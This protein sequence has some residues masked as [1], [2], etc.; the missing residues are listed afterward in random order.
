MLAEQF[1]PGPLTIILP[2]LPSLAWD[3]GDSHGTVAL[4]IPEHAVAL[5]LLRQTGPLAVTGAQHVGGHVP[6]TVI[7]AREHLD[8]AVAVYLDGGPVAGGVSS[9][10]DAT[11]SPPMLVREGVLSLDRLRE[12]VP[13]LIPAGPAASEAEVAG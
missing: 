9:V 3:L 2:A 1:W 12:V 8:G 7:E 4:R 11:V 10:V 13:L 6:T 5:D